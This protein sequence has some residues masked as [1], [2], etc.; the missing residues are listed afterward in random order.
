MSLPLAWLI[1]MATKPQ[2]R[3]RALIVFFIVSILAT[4][5]VIRANLWGRPFTQALMWAQQNP[6]SPRAQNYL[7]NFWQETG[8]DNE[9]IALLMGALRHNP[10]DLLTRLNLTIA[11]CSSHFLTQSD[12]TLLNK[13]IHTINTQSPV[14]RYQVETAIRKLNGRY[15]GEWSPNS[16]YE[17]LY[18]AIQ[19]L[20]ESQSP[21]W[22][23]MLL[24]LYAEAALEKQ[25]PYEA[26]NA[27]ILALQ[28]KSSWQKIISNAA[29]LAD[30][31]H[32]KLALSLMDM[33]PRPV[34]T[35]KQNFRISTLRDIWL[36]H[37]GY[38]DHEF[39]N[40]RNV[41]IQDIQ[42]LK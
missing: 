11:K 10:K 18:N 8:N 26:Y 28:I 15:C 32:P 34:I 33:A 5:T 6:T 39:K 35:E 30:A 42:D 23:Q 17:L 16:Y 9:A 19:Q 4:H 20:S 36:S 1:V 29:I 27:L 25:Q 40:L 31:G 24:Q 14:Q 38:Y 13:T 7:A 22:R 3:K 21:I 2:P 12:I 41:I 37:I